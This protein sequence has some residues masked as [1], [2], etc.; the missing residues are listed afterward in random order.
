VIIWGSAPGAP[1]AEASY[2]HLRLLT[3]NG[4][5]VLR[6]FEIAPGSHTAHIG[7]LP[8]PCA[9]PMSGAGCP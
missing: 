5:T 3:D 2:P 6:T 9:T 7:Y 1:L 8:A 4:Q